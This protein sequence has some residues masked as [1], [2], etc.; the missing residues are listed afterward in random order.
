[1]TG[2]VIYDL[3]KWMPGHG[4]NGLSVNFEERT[5]KVEVRFDEPSGKEVSRTIRFSGVSFHSVGAFPGVLSIAGKYESNFSTGTVIKTQ[6]S[7]LS[8]LW[9]AHWK[10][11]GIERRCL[12]F[13]MF[14]G[15]ENKVI[16]VVAESVELI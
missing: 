13:V 6:N 5:L 4:E 15:A 2:Q 9:T 8:E 7:E 11:S 16:H 14:W 3:N 1:M 12:H 10:K